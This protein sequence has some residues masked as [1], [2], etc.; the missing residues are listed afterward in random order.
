[1]RLGAVRGESIGAKIGRAT[2][3]TAARSE[4]LYRTAAVLNS[5]KEELALVRAQFIL[6][7]FLAASKS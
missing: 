4:Y 2:R 6:S 1:M 3:Q 5:A 7:A